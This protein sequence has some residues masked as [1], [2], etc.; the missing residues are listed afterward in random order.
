MSRVGI[1]RLRLVILTAPSQR[2]GWHPT[3]RP[4]ISWNYGI[5]IVPVDCVIITALRI[6]TCRSGDESGS[7]R[8]SNPKPQPRDFSQ[9]TQRSTIP[10]TSNAILSADPYFVVFASMQATAWALAVV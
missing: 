2:M 9:P 1:F 4:S 3:V 7:S 6:L 10:S 8:G 5:F